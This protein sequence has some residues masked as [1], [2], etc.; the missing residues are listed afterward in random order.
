MRE[1]S[2]TESNV[3]NLPSEAGDTVTRT[4]HCIVSCGHD[5][6]D[7]DHG[8][9]CERS[10]GGQANGVTEPGWQEVQFWCSVIGPYIHGTVSRAHAAACDRNRNGVRLTALTRATETFGWRELG[11]NLTAG[12]ARQLAAH[13]VAAADSHD[14]ID[15]THLLWDRV[16]KLGQAAG[17]VW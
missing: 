5:G 8:P 12:E 13:L 17:I 15:R 7:F 2:A 9:Y 3:S 16:T 4:G 1:N 10:V 11:Y 6:A 14:G